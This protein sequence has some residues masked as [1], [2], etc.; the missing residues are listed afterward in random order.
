MRTLVVFSNKKINAKS[1]KYSRQKNLTHP[2]MTSFGEVGAK[3]LI[4]E[5]SK[6]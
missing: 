1:K 5:L 6:R 3:K 4:A 2:Y